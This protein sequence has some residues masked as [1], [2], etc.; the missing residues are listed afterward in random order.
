MD[1]FE[2]LQLLLLLHNAPGGITSVPVA[3]RL[4]DV[5]MSQVRRLATDLAEGGL[6][7]HS[8]TDLIELA[9]GSIEERL[10]LADLAQ[11]YVKDRGVVLGRLAALK[12][13]TS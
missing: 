7:R 5:S 3:A 2:K 9:I 4:I 13:S 10:A 1:S 12:R 8:K 11:S 6:V